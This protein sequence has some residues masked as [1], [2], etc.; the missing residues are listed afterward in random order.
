VVDADAE[1]E[2]A[3]GLYLLHGA[4]DALRRVDGIQGPDLIVFSVHPAVAFAFRPSFGCFLGET[5]SINEYG[6]NN[7]FHGQLTM[8]L[9]LPGRH[10]CDRQLAT[11]QSL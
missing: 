7:R 10:V 6:D 5:Y 3:A 2:H 11:T 1:V 4:K 9:R 8:I